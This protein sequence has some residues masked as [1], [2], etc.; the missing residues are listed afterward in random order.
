MT[1]STLSASNKSSN[2][3]DDEEEDPFAIEVLLLEL[4][5]LRGWCALASEDTRSHLPARDSR[6]VASFKQIPAP[7]TPLVKV[8]SEDKSSFT[9][10]RVPKAPKLSACTCHWYMYAATAKY[11]IIIP[12]EVEDGKI[13]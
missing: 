11:I 13:V 12:N 3:E 5:L 1:S 6:E 9:S 8:F 7:M 10:V 4:L 2:E